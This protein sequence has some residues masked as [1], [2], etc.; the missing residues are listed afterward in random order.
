M[1][2][3]LGEIIG[4]QYKTSLW[5]LNG[6]PYYV[7]VSHQPMHACIVGTLSRVWIIRVMMAANPARGQLNRENDFFLSPFVP[8]NLVSRDEFGRPVPR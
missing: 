1:S 3:H 6:F 5:H 7:G 4:C 2:K 8:E